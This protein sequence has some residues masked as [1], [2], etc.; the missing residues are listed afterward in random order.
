MEN[1][2]KGTTENGADSPT[3][4]DLLGFGRLVEQV[5]WKITNVSSKETPL[6]IGIYGEWGSGK[7][8]FLKMVDES[9]RKDEI[10][11]IW[12]NAWKYDKEDNLWAALIQTILNQAHINGKWHRRLW[13]KY[14]IWR[15]TI[16]FSTGFWEFLKWLI[17][18]GLRFVIVIF[19]VTI[20]LG[21]S[22]AE[23]S[24]FL[25]QLFARWF[26]SKPLLLNFFQTSVIKVIIGLVTFFALN[27]TEL[28]K[29]IS[30]VNLGLDFSKFQ[31]KSSSY[32]SHIAFLDEFSDEFK[33][34]IK[35]VGNG[36]P[37]V[38][39]IDDLDRCL[40]E[41]AIQVLEAIKL[42][43]D[44]EGCVFIL[45]VDR[46]V[47]EKAI[48]S[49][50]KELLTLPKETD[51]KPQYLAAFLGENYFEKIVQLPISLLPISEQQIKD[52]IVNLYADDDVKLCSS[53]FAVGLP[54]NP[55]K[56]K[57]LLHT[58]SFIRGLASNDIKNGSI[59]PSLL[60]KLVLIQS[61][62]RRLYEEIVE[63]PKLLPALETYFRNESANNSP[64]DSAE[65]ILNEKVQ[66]FATQFPLLRKILLQEV[67]DND[68]FEG[69]DIEHYI[70]L[71]TPLAE[72]SPLPD[73]EEKQSLAL[74]LGKY[75]RALIAETQHLTISG[76]SITQRILVSINSI[77]IPRFHKSELM[78]TED[79]EAQSA[80]LNDI[81]V[82]ST[83]FVL[84]G[85]PGSGKTT[86]LRYLANIFARVFSQND[87]ESITVQIG[88][89]ERLLPIYIRLLDYGQYIESHKDTTPS[90]SGF[91]EFLDY[92]I[93]NWRI[94]LQQG[95]FN[96]YF[97]RGNCI[98]LLDGFDEVGNIST[99]QFIAR[100]IIS[101]AKR[102]PTMR[103][104]VTSRITGYQSL[105][106]GEDFAVY[107]I[108]PLMENEI[109]E[110]IQKWMNAVYPSSQ[111]Q[112]A[113]ESSE[114]ISAISLHLPLRMLAS[115]PLLLTVIIL[116]FFSGRK[117]PDN[118][119]E[120]YR[121]VT[122]VLLEN[123]D[124]VKGL[125]VVGKNKL[126]P[127]HKRRILEKLAFEIH[128]AKPGG[129][130]DK[131]FI[132][133]VLETELN[134]TNLSSV[135]TVSEL[136]SDFTERSGVL[137]ERSLGQYGFLHLTFEEYFAALELAHRN[138]CVQIVQSKYKNLRWQEVI[139]L[140][141]NYLVMTNPIIAEEIVGLLL[142]SN[143]P[144][145][146]II[147]GVCI[148]ENKQRLE[149][150]FRE[151]TIQ[152]LGTI[153]S[154][155]TIEDFLRERARNILDELMK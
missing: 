31:K 37:F 21:W 85:S 33:R 131:T 60:A 116:S 113:E 45:A 59:K 17:P 152:A 61:Q 122:D 24:S 1:S 72:T 9:L 103:M 43:L 11:P 142:K 94:D 98:I 111:A 4:K 67:T 73:S 145:G 112:A 90:P 5:V 151:R 56:V 83:R 123:W 38:V 114:L 25:N 27:P 155:E 74:L 144:E 41:K 146:I 99:R 36:K 89:S 109:S 105:S 71:V 29:I 121:N 137:V 126:E 77:F 84:L 150:K 20:I 88:I 147:A 10:Y 153:S 64:E 12:F 115:N 53:I 66:M 96:H 76:I 58:F 119:L 141:V 15:D 149:T 101:L 79:T 28:V 52:F 108:L 23:I 47:V 92:Y 130:V 3:T 107:E 134:L 154:D 57:R 14:K 129:T 42:F 50:Y 16:D 102:Y 49:K 62:F 138:D 143:E 18:V 133:S 48:T 91:L 7:T 140:S 40:P 80:S 34:I 39:V 81:L 132:E 139:L 69:V 127:V 117:I 110:F 97:D 2:T 118:R 135:I 30:G 13:V 124:L 78:K 26:S 86:I 148:L 106:L 19:G 100:S 44:V 104:I 125:E 82:S 51:S 32:R 120:L 22:S 95:F 136:I 46:E 54:H 55:R 65:S 8:S 75:L 70:F 6:T 35:L 68:S 87:S 63:N 128:E 93:A